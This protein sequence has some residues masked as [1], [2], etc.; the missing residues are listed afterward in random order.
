MRNVFDGLV[1]RLC[2]TQKR[3]FELESI[4]LEASKTEKKTE[5]KTW[6]TKW[7]KANKKQPETK[8]PR[9]VVQG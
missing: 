5:K 8:Y 2:T 9:T 1:G 3:I 4:L 7:N 6:K